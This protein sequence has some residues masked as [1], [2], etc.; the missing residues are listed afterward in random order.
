MRNVLM[1]MKPAASQ[2][3]I[4]ATCSGFDHLMEVQ[5][6]QRSLRCTDDRR[7]FDWEPHPWY[8]PCDAIGGN[9]N[10]CSQCAEEAWQLFDNLVAKHC[11]ARVRIVQWKAPRRAG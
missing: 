3:G 5:M 2:A 7:C 9:G 1:Y 4:F 8:G 10:W 6:D 11:R